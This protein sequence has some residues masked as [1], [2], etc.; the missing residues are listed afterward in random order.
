MLDEVV[1]VVDLIKR[2]AERAAL[3]VDHGFSDRQDIPCSL[4]I[5]HCRLGFKLRGILNRTLFY[6]QNPFCTFQE[7]CWSPIVVFAASIVFS[8][9]GLWKLALIQVVFFLGIKHRS[10]LFFDFAL[11]EIDREVFFFCFLLLILKF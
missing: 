8:L 10:L 2:L 5:H 11:L 6:V 7:A 1:P 4:R 9:V 3:I